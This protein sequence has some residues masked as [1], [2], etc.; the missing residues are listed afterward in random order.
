[1]SSKYNNS[2]YEVTE[3]H[4]LKALKIAI[5]DY[6]RFAKDNTSSDWMECQNICLG[7]VEHLGMLSILT[8]NKLMES[9]AREDS[10]GDS[11]FVF[12][13]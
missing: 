1:M 6:K 9:I 3:K 2:N 5:S 7:M 11:D 4:V 10:D 13:E 8:R 12:E